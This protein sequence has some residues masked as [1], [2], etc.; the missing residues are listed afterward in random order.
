MGF[1]IDHFN[2]TSKKVLIG[3]GRSNK[4]SLRYPSKKRSKRVWTTFYKMF[5]KV[6]LS[7]GWDGCSSSKINF[8]TK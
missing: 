7:D 6:A 5:P 1:L 2:D 4:N 8:K 3:S